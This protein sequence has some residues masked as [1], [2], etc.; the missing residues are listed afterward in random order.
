M[1]KHS[2]VCWREGKWR[3]ISGWAEPENA[4]LL[5]QGHHWHQ[6]CSSINCVNTEHLQNVKKKQTNLC[7]QDKFVNLETTLLIRIYKHLMTYP[8][9]IFNRNNGVLL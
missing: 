9:R 3:W 5:E 1:V 8:C 7:A 4:G 2:F 6:H